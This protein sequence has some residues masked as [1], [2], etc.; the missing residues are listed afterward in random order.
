ML[1]HTI[2]NDDIYWRAQLVAPATCH[3]PH[4]TSLSFM[5]FLDIYRLRSYNRFALTGFAGFQQKLCVLTNAQSK[6]LCVCVGAVAQRSIKNG[7]IQDTA[8]AFSS[9]WRRQAAANQSQF[10]KEKK[11]D[12]R[13]T[14]EWHVLADTIRQVRKS[15]R[16]LDSK[17]QRN[18]VTSG[19][20]FGC[21]AN[22]SVLA[23]SWTPPQSQWS[24]GLLTYCI[25]LQFSLAS[26]TYKQGRLTVSR[27]S[28][29]TL[30]VLQR[31][32]KVVRY[33]VVGNSPVFHF[34]FT[35]SLQ[36]V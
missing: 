5:G 32:H 14:L 23:E 2:P 31:C 8:N 1:L 33:N 36:F 22:G 15:G 13:V 7:C 18:R 20:D 3:L 34:T 27:W 10:G 17:E 28:L 25:A 35:K 16:G 9:R 26:I 24:T 12:L 19:V 21:P 29:N 11:K 30:D 4:A 6:C